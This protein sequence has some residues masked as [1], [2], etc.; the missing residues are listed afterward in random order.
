MT[1][2]VAVVV[3]MGLLVGGR[4]LCT[5]SIIYYFHCGIGVDRRLLQCSVCVAQ[6]SARKSQLHLW[7]PVLSADILSSSLRNQQPVRGGEEERVAAA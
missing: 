2:A 6:S 1:M 3:R 5:P 7:L 4:C